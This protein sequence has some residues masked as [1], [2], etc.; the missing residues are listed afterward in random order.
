MKLKLTTESLQYWQDNPITEYRAS[1]RLSMLEMLSYVTIHK[2]YEDIAV[3][4]LPKQKTL[5]D[6][7]YH[8]VNL[9]SMLVVGRCRFD[10]LKTFRDTFGK[11]RWMLDTTDPKRM[12]LIA[13]LGNVVT[14]FHCRLQYTIVNEDD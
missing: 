5:D 3:I 7:W 8:I 13:T 1:L 10:D 11:V 4:K 9:T 2:T 12:T 6:Q 14:T